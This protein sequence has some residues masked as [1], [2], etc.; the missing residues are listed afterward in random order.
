MYAASVQDYAA[1]PRYSEVQPPEPQGDEV[2]VTMLAAAVS[3]LVRAQA[4]GKHYSSPKTL[5]FVPGVDGIGRLADGTRVYCS[6]PRIPHGTMAEQTVVPRSQC[7]AM[8]DD[9]D[10]VTAAAIANPGMSSWVALKQRARFVA[11]ESVL[12]NGATGASGRLAIQIAKHLGARR[13]IAT[14]RT[15]KSVG[16]LTALGADVTIALDQSAAHLSEIFHRELRDPGVDVVL[17]YLWGHSAELII[18]ASGGHGGQTAEPR[19]RFV[20]IG[21]LSGPTISLHG[22][23]LRS[24]GLEL[25]GSGLGSVS[26]PGLVSAVGEMLHAV[27][28]AGLQVDAEPAPLSDVESAW[29]EERSTRLVLTM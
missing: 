20:Q 18:A 15:A 19:V 22:G 28:P 10:A 17:D 8:P 2:V 29:E 12:I 27:R 24:S 3:Q 23:V 5:P 26:H 13:V 4:S 25:I 9:L 6:F 21:N 14:G 11:G 16:P 7:V 1:A